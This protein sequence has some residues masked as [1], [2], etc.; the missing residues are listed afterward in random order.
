MI[1]RAKQYAKQQGVSVSE[2]VENYLAAVAEPAVRAGSAA[3]WAMV[4]R[5]DAEGML[6]GHAVTRR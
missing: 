6:C 4:E 2:L 1:G 3:L 5:G